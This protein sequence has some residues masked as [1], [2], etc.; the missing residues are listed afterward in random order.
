MSR[1]RNVAGCQ[2]NDRICVA[3]LFNEV[4]NILKE[5][6]LPSLKQMLCQ[7]CICE[8]DR[9]A[10]ENVKISGCT[11]HNNTGGPWVDDAGDKE[12]VS[13]NGE[14]EAP[15][16]VIKSVPSDDSIV[17]EINPGGQNKGECES[18]EEN[19][20]QQNMYGNNRRRLNQKPSRGDAG[21]SGQ[22]ECCRCETRSAN[23]G[24]ER[25]EGSYGQR[26]KCS[27]SRVK[28][29]VKKGGDSCNKPPR[30][31]R[32]CDGVAYSDRCANASTYHE[33]SSPND[34]SNFVVDTTDY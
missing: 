1:H 24:N 32:S 9:I 31:K 10:V 2:K 12:S 27:S 23:S 22:Q 8:I 15:L 20:Q 18:D 25:S 34:K 5:N 26:P 6:N 30:P 19:N 7:E 33:I 13:E 17:I 11:K 4:S 3:C 28:I 14:D 16:V 21:R 29:T